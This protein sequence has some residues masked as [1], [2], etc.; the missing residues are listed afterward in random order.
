MNNTEP[1]QNPSSARDIPLDP[2]IRQGMAS[3]PKS[4]VWVGASAGTGKTK[5]L[6]DRVLRLLM[7]DE[8]G[9]AH[10]KPHKILCLTFTKAA[11]SE[12]ALRVNEILSKWSV[13]P[14]DELTKKLEKLLN[15]S[16]NRTDLKTARRLFADVIETSGGIKIMTIHGFC[17]SVLSRFPLEAGLPPYFDAI[18]EPQAA[19]FLNQAQNIILARA[20]EER[21]SPLAHAL[22]NIAST[23]DADSFFTVLGAMTAERHKTSDIL[24]KHFGASGLYT[25]LCRE[26]G[27]DPNHS[28]E[29]ILKHACEDYAFDKTGLRT[30]CGV[31]DEIGGIAEKKK[32]PTLQKWLNANTLERF[33][34]FDE[35]SLIYMTV[36]GEPRKKLVN[37][38]IANNRP[39]ALDT[40]HKE[41]IRVMGIQNRVNMAISIHLTRDLF[42][43]GHA[44]IKEYDSIKTEHAVLDFDD[45][46]LKTANLLRNHTNEIHID[47]KS[48]P[49]APWVLYKLDQGLD[50]I[51]VDE[52]QDT[53]PEQ[54]GIIDALSDEFFAGLGRHEEGAESDRTV[55][56]VGDEK[57]S[58][59]SFQ[60]ASPEEFFKTQTRLSSKVKEAQN[61]WHDV[62]LN[63]SFR[64]SASVLSAVDA[65]FSQ[66]IVSDGL[67]TKPINHIPYRQG[68]EGI[69]ELW[70]LHK[71]VKQE[72]QPT[73]WENPLKLSETHDAAA[74]LAND[75]ATRIKLWIDSKTKLQSYDRPI[76]A[77][78]IMILM[79]TRSRLM[80]LITAALKKNNI[81]VSGVDR[82]V[83]SEELIIQ[84]LIAIAQYAICPEDDLTLAT[85]L[86]SP[87]IG[88]S[89]Q[90]LYSLC[91]D[92]D[93]KPLDQHIK[94]IAPT[95]V[96]SYLQEIKAQAR[97]ASPYEFFTHILQSP[98]PASHKTG[99][100]AFKKRLGNDIQD[101]INEFLSLILDFERN[102]PPN[103]QLFLYNFEKN[104]IEIKRDTSERG[105]SVRIMT[106]HGSKGLQA[107]IVIMPDT[108]R[109]SGGG[110]HKP[111]ERLLWPHKTELPM[112]IWSP[113]K[114]TEFDTYTNAYTT[115][116]EKQNQEYRRLLYVAMTRAESHLYIAGYEG[117]NKT[118]E[119]SWYKY[120]ENALRSHPDIKNMEDGTLR[121]HNPNTAQADKISDQKNNTEHS[122]EYDIPDW[123]YAPAPD[124]P[125]PPRPLVPSR[126]ALL[127]PDSIS[128][129][130]GASNNRFTRGNLTHRLLEL[131]P[132]LTP[133]TR[134]NAAN[135][136]LNNYAPDK[137]EAFK[138][139][140][141]DEI[142]KILDNPLYSEIFG[143]NSR[144]EVPVTGLINNK[145]MVSGQ[146]DRMLITDDTIWIVDYKTNR[147]PPKNVEDVPQSYLLQIRTYIDVLKE[148]YPKHEIHGALLWTDGPHLMPLM[149]QK[150]A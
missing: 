38:D 112:P 105:K 23:V 137:S 7:P 66:K 150:P 118:N 136:Y 20:S 84:D 16:I 58:I 39:D 90:T 33:H 99:L 57:Q 145:T 141:I 135:T 85:I 64:S 104:K 75:I 76:E 107:P 114:S 41:C 8:K 54:W 120:I 128:P 131:L 47:L 149:I 30:L 26:Y 91:I 74:A 103:L 15:R 63:I 142:F 43:I 48:H 130:M 111:G 121:L 88:L 59:Y 22:N 3:N 34:M 29:D 37:K 147:P 134:K 96:L 106:I 19:Q 70:P 50:H 80:H 100:N 4:S 51:L 18:E 6:T 28:P 86:K 27:I 119:D 139:S 62:N 10:T 108:I 117:K 93:G 79:R 32:L 87:M 55:F 2:N 127:E 95:N 125:T 122:F 65:T 46:I 24:Q 25:A 83:L 44:I 60:R 97:I 132:A 148:I 115:M 72:N 42:E 61:E 17:Q 5:V 144:A 133:A 138:S 53:N 73:F 81:E 49:L 69:V 113:R 129:L 102:N 45:L 94:N 68:Q 9:F 1:N 110:G 98:C 146:I 40:M 140:I 78:D 123:I 92:R 36:K 67:G 14:E 13:M 31:I 143:K 109:T 116:R 101:A 71:T 56:V 89:E 11:A 77:G 126:P 35:Y 82:L 124:E 21:T 12:M 52:A